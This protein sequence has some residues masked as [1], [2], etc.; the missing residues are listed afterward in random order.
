MAEAASKCPLP[1]HILEFSPPRRRHPWSGGP[2]TGAATVC[3]LEHSLNDRI[4][5]PHPNGHLDASFVEQYVH[6]LRFTTDSLAP[7]NTALRDTLPADATARLIVFVDAGVSEAWPDLAGR[8]QAYAAT[9]DDRMKLAGPVMT[10]PG[11]EAAKNDWEVFE[12][13]ARAIN[14][15]G[16]CR[17]SFVVTIG[18]GAVLD[19]VGFGAATAHRGVRLIRLPTTTLSQ[20]DGG[21]GVKNGINAFGKKNFLGCFAVPWAVINDDAFLTSLPDR[22]W[23]S[24]LSEAVKVA[25]LKDAA[26]FDLIE[27][28]AD[29]LRARN[30]RRLV[31]IVRRTAELHLDHIVEGGDPFEARGERPLDFGHWSA[32]KLEQ[33]TDFEVKHGEAVAIGLAIDVLYSATI[34]R[35]DPATAERCVRALEAIGF[36][37]YHDALRDPELFDGIDEFREHLG[38]MLAITLIDEIGRGFEANDI[39]RGAMVAAIGQLADRTAQPQSRRIG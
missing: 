14:D 13:V 24:G 39:D 33:M 22:D 4:H 27:S 23:R 6:R 38:G 5:D 21:I 31:P 28:S 37:L 18:G 17:H 9:H 7:Q 26:F 1:S 15:H 20:A 36:D 12:R 8:L 32:H 30:H 35:L 16:I 34:G 10:V 19:A 2:S 29:D 11:G 3:S 25:L